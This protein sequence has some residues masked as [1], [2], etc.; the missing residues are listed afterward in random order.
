MWSFYRKKTA[1]A[2][3]RKGREKIRKVRGA[4]PQGANAN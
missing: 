2:L 4:N 3:N 1:K